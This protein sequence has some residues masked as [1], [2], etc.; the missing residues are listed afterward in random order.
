MFGFSALGG[1]KIIVWLKSSSLMI[2]CKNVLSVFNDP[3]LRIGL[4]NFIWWK[5]LKK[6]RKIKAL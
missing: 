5:K 3:C 4:K 6:F 2:G 1:L